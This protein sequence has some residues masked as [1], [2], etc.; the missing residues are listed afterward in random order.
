M[1]HETRLNQSSKVDAEIGAQFR[2]WLSHVAAGPR[3]GLEGLYDEI[4]AA[5]R[6]GF[7]RTPALLALS[8]LDTRTLWK[9]FDDDELQD[10]YDW[11]HE[12]GES[13]AA[14]RFKEA[15]I[16][17]PRIDDGAVPPQVWELVMTRDG[18]RCQLCEATDDLT[19]DH[20]II[21]YSEGGSSKDPDN[22]QVLCRSCNSRKGTRPWAPSA[23]SLESGQGLPTRARRGRRTRPA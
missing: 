3:D 7:P 2:S 4:A 11:S 20:K 6:S 16:E 10:L 14:E 12:A 22:L 19:I 13:A 21:P 8:K 15:V 1:G 18:R 23:M 9:A 17:A 5:G